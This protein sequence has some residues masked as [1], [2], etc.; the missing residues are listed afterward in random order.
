MTEL[1]FAAEQVRLYDHDRYLTAIFAP[2]GTRDHAFAL[3]AF[4]VEIAKT[5]EVVTERLIGQIRL[6]WWRDALDKLYA[7][8]TIAHEVA[9]PLGDAIRVAGLER[10]LFDQLIDAREADLE[11]GPPPTLAALEAYAEATAA[12]LIELAIGLSGTRTS[13]ATEAAARA[14]GAAWALTG[15]MRAVP[16]HAR[17]HR[18]FLPADRLGATG[19]RTGR[20]FDLKPDPAL[21]EV[22]G[23]VGERALARLEEARG[24]ISAV[25]RAGRWPLLLGVLARLYLADLRGAGWNP[26]EPRL[27]RGRPLAI[28]HLATQRLLRRY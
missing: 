5:R 11:D 8:E 18:L 13:P 3:Y 24:L 4:N 21:A 7:G 12:P 1:G 14:V 19:I 6:Q 23:D 26:F 9:R 17:Q 10:R 16:F 15:L 25:P 22:V 20:L 28:W 27:A 2:S